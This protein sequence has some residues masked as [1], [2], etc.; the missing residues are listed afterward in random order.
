MKDDQGSET[1]RER[2]H[3]GKEVPLAL[4]FGML[5]QTGAAVWWA[6]GQVANDENHERRLGTLERERDIT[7]TS[8]RMA[9]IEAAIADIRRSNERM[10]VLMQQ[11]LSQRGTRP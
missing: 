5:V 10:E 2:W 4:I 11:V 3:F 6:R 7:K 9:V 1:R 8:E